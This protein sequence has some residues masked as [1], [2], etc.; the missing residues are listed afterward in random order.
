MPSK[1][2]SAVTVGLDAEKIEIECDAGTGQFHFI[3]VGLPD[4]AVQEARERVRAAIKNSGC[5]FPRGRV[6]VNLAPA[7]IK[8]QGS[9]Y[10]VPIALSILLADP[11]GFMG[12]KNSDG[13]VCGMYCGELSLEGNVRPVSGVLAIAQCAK[14]AGCTSLFVPRENASEA[15]LVE[16]IDIYPI[17]TLSQCI[18]HLTGA[19]SIAPHIRSSC[20]MEAVTEERHSAST[21]DFAHIK[22]QHHAKRALEIAAAGGHNILLSGQ[23]GSGKTLLARGIAPLLPPLSFDEALEVTRIYSVMGMMRPEQSLIRERPFRSPHHTASVVSIIGGGSM[24]MPGEISLSH[25]GVLFLDEFP[26]FP[27]TVLEAL[28]QPLE[29]GWVTVTRAAGSMRFP[30]RCILVA[31]QNP[32]PCGNYG[33]DTRECA[34][35]L[36]AIRSYQKKISGPILDRIDL[37]VDVPPVQYDELVSQSMSESSADVRARVMHARVIQQQ[38]YEKTALVVNGEMDNLSLASFCSLDEKTRIFLRSAAERFRLSARSYMRVVKIARTIADL[39]GSEHVD[40][41]HVAESLQYRPCQE[42]AFRA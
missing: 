31:A 41:R 15:S 3:I 22:G 39:E 35:S 4:A 42:T 16:G 27:R 18:E 29:D 14:D 13:V 26:E 1:V 38:R 24:P 37:F 36:T 9:L 23:P 12:G 8:K 40:Q 33:S 7:D 21:V 6:T 19:Q 32:C 28:R 5:P 11:E 34:C 10:D 25:R 20:S 30:A 17:A 2:L